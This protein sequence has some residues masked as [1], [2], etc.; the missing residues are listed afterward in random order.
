MILPHVKTAP[1]RETHKAKKT[2]ANN[3]SFLRLFK[4]SKYGYRNKIKNGSKG[5]NHLTE[6][7][8]PP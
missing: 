5:T 8:S 4:F 6:N 2:I 7:E 1:I 3:I